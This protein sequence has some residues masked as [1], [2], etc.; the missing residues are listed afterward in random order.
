MIV[1]QLFDPTSSTYTYLLAD[2]RTR[3]A[4]VIDCVF[5]QHAR[6]A[7]LVRELGVTLRFALD[8]HCHADHVTGAWLMKRAFGAQIGLASIYGAAEIDR[9][10]AHGDTI[11]FGDSALDVRATPGHTDGCLAYVTSDRRAVFTGDALLVRGAGRTDFQQ[12]DAHRLFH[13]IR[14]Q[15][16]TL[17]EDCVMY[18][19]HDYEGRT[20]STIGEERRFNARI[21]G[22]AREEDFVGYMTN[23]GLPHPKQLAVAVPVNLRA[24]KPEAG[25]ETPVADWGPLVLTYAGIS[26]IAPEWLARHRG[27]VQILDV[28]NP[29]ELTG[30]LGHLGDALAIPLDALRARSDEV[31][32]DKP[33]VVVCQT[34]RRSCLATVILR[35]AGIARCA[36]LAGGMVRWHEL[37]L[38]LAG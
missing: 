1:R 29:S 27:D 12:G 14:D 13:S 20:S 36:S 5:E 2:E 6:D 38:P 30:D 15:L 3:D 18:P 16:F 22:G 8:T 17:P 33:V 32:R 21:G 31:T 28:R 34:G 7:A 37:G 35:K 4:V 24:G 25:G 19:G 9:P 26:E 23:L 10:L 11:R